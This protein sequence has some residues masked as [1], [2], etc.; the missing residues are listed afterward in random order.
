MS[1]DEESERLEAMR[2]EKIL[3]A[4]MV[5]FLLIG[6]VQVLNELGGVPDRPQLGTYYAK[7]DVYTLEAEE[8]SIVAELNSAV[9]P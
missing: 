5:I 9:L 2:G 7:Y 1:E 6:G 4:A 8:R 3:A